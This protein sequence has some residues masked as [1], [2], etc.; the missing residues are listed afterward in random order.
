M[1]RLRDLYYAVMDL[2]RASSMDMDRGVEIKTLIRSWG[3]ML[4]QPIQWN[5]LHIQQDADAPIWEADAAEAR[6]YA[7]Y[8]LLYLPSDSQQALI[9]EE[10]SQQVFIWNISSTADGPNIVRMLQ[11]LEKCRWQQISFGL[12]HAQNTE[13]FIQAQYMVLMPSYLMDV[14]ALAAVFQPQSTQVYQFFIN[15]YKTKTHSKYIVKG[16]LANTI[17]SFL[18]LSP[19][20]TFDAIFDYFKQSNGLD[21]IL[22]TND[23]LEEL[24]QAG[25]HI[26]YHIA[27][28][29]D[30]LN[31]D[32]RQAQ[33]Y[34]ESSYINP[35]D[36]IQGRLD[37]L[38]MN[39]QKSEAE[40]FE[41][42][43][44]KVYKPMD[45]GVNRN[46][47]MQ[48]LLYERMVAANESTVEQVEANVYYVSL[49]QQRIRPMDYA[50]TS[51]LATVHARNKI[52]SLIL[53]DLNLPL[54]QP[55]IIERIKA[56]T[57]SGI[58]GFALQDAAA[59]EQHFAQMDD[60]E[61]KYFRMFNQLLGIEHLYAKLGSNDQ[62]QQSFADMWRL[63]VD[64]KI[65]RYQIIPQAQLIKIQIEEGNTFLF[66]ALDNKNKIS[67]F[68]EG[69]IVL[70]YPSSKL[71]FVHKG[72]LQKANIIRYNQSE[73]ILRLR[74]GFSN[75]EQFKKDQYWAIERDYIESSSAKEYRALVSFFQ[76]ENEQ[77]EIWMGRKAPSFPLTVDAAITQNNEV[78]QDI[79]RRMIGCGSYF[80]LWGPPGTGKT[81]VVLKA[82]V[83][84]LFHAS[85]EKVLI[86]AY[87]NR[88]VEEISHVLNADDQIKA[89]YVRIGS[90]NSIKPELHT[91]LLNNK[92]KQFKT[93]TEKRTFVQSRKIVLATVSSFLGA[94]DICRLIQFDRLIVDEASQI[95]DPSIIG[96]AA[97]MPKVNL[98]GDY[99]QLPA[100]VTQ[101]VEDTKIED[102]DLNALGI[103]SASMSLFERLYRRCLHQKWDAALGQLHHQGRMHQE[104][105]QFVSKHF[106]QNKLKVLDEEI[107]GSDR[108]VAALTTV[109]SQSLQPYDRRLAF[110]HA[111]DDV[112]ET[113]VLYKVSEQ[114]AR[115][116]VRY[117]QFVKENTAL[118]NYTIGIICPFKAQIVLVKRHLEKAFDEIPN[119]VIIDT[120]ERFQG[121]AIDF[122]F[123][124][125]CAQTERSFQAAQSLDLDGDDRKLNVALS[126]AREQIVL[127]GNKHILQQHIVYRHYIES[128][129]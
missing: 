106:Y 30:R 2:R 47:Y 127:V 39:A 107:L 91:H 35:Q 76:A 8:T 14:T 36:G 52:I 51:F 29:L 38:L 86:L 37:L 15:R 80:L 122:V 41:L 101:A 10:R 67:N 53:S 123:I 32:A 25:Q 27:D 102:A 3:I 74:S 81:T 94:Q 20:E 116:A 5:A 49:E 125:T 108:L 124:S 23:E 109:F 56:D 55:Q 128:F 66:F 100:V 33:K 114:E 12:H 120:V 83:Q 22:L 11:W 28:D 90:R 82:L 26:F 97:R 117:I 75:A 40:I 31:W 69:D 78:T 1:I 34:L 6:A 71:D 19:H 121:A 110:I 42:K 44:G 24:K 64:E 46:H 96:L 115:E 73:V 95:L 112:Q 59:N 68:R 126:R 13:F 92:L 113:R 9:L 88:A 7:T 79:L 77:R 17:M 87:T 45:N 50:H 99:K 60:V 70:I 57:F 93:I 21:L 85:E 119:E 105:C 84:K 4:D 98:I 48:T 63:S 58:G 104:I 54:D 16:N 62:A 89:H 18:L 65:P 129:E 111:Q 72:M 103:T 61:R 43:S 118:Q